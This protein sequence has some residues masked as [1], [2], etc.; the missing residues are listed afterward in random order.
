MENSAMHSK[1]DIRT[2]HRPALKQF[3]SPKACHGW[4]LDRPAVPSPF[5][6]VPAQPFA[7]P[8]IMT[9]ILYYIFILHH[10]YLIIKKTKIR[11]Y[12]SNFSN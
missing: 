8:V 4:R 1:I 9:V 6:T 10:N 2:T 12:K 7:M 11:K 3:A 5:T